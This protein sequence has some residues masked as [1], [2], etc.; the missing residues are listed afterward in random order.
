MRLPFSRYF[1]PHKLLE[2]TLLSRGSFV[3]TIIY[4]YYIGLETILVPKQQNGSRI[5]QEVDKSGRNKQ[6]QTSSL[7]FYGVRC[8]VLASVDKVVL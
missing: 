2:L 7:Y 3:F 8:D 6:R 5:L 4:I 1:S